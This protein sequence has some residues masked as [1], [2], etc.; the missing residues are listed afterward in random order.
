MTRPA[1]RVAVLVASIAAL[2]APALW[3]AARGETRVRHLRTESPS[4][5]PL[6]EITR[7]APDPR[8]PAALL[9]HGFQCNKSMMVPLARR[10]AGA[11][12]DVYAVDLPGHGASHERFS[13]ERAEA[14]VRE[15]LESISAARGVASEGLALVGHSYGANVLARVAGERRGNTRL[16]MIGPGYAGGLSPTTGN[17]LVL[18]AERDYPYI[19]AFA[20][21]MLRDATAGAIVA[22]GQAIGAPDRGDARAWRVVPGENHL[23]LLLSDT[24]STEVLTWIAGALARTSAPDAA[25]HVALALAVLAI[26]GAGVLSTLAASARTCARAAPPADDAVATLASRTAICVAAVAIAAP[27]ARFAPPLAFLRLLEGGQ[28][29]SLIV[30]AGLLANGAHL[31]IWRRTPVPTVPQLARAVPLALGAF[32]LHYGA[33]ALGLDGELYH[34]SLADAPPERPAAAVLLSLALL[35]FFALVQGLSSDPR[36]GPGARARWR[37]IVGAACAVAALYGAIAV[38]L[39]LLGP[40]AGRFGLSILTI[41]AFCAVVGAL[42]GRASRNPAVGVM[43]SAMTTAWAIAVGF[44]RY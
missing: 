30:V 1:L 39:P 6:L 38:A 26:V 44:V 14:A 5:L 28:I 25:P 17:L 43:F 21:D 18:T 15:A 12:I 29:A 16:V 41:G 27:I 3:Q 19:T 22:P 32:A 24:V 36:G 42:L 23:S 37:R 8:R 7:G 4:R 13:E 10:L 20:R 31:V 2:L 35:P 11:G 34:V 40:L 9:V 33:A